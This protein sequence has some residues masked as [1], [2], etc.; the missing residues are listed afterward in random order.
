MS[1][2]ESCVVWKRVANLTRENHIVHNYIVKRK[3][4]KK[5]LSFI[6]EKVAFQASSNSARSKPHLHL[7]LCMF[8]EGYTFM[9]A[10]FLISCC[11]LCLVFILIRFH[12][13]V[14][15]NFHHSRKVPQ[16]TMHQINCNSYFAQAWFPLKLACSTGK[17]RRRSVVKC[18]LFL[19][20]PW[21]H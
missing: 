14:P 20:C 1:Q 2:L 18:S 11:S 3:K 21:F 9:Y 17:L 13:S 7:F 12:F 16:A 6:N 10:F 19:R 5:N 15:F 4:N 8:S